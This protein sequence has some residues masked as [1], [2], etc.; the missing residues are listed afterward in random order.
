M[1]HDEMLDAFVAAGVDRDEL[2]SAIDDEYFD[3]DG[4]AIVYY[5]PGAYERLLPLLDLLDDVVE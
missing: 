2:V 1:T 4:M 3:N 5:P